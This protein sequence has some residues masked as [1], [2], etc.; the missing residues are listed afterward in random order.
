[1][2][3]TEGLKKNDDFRTVYKTGR[4][5]SHPLFILYVKEN[6]TESN[7]L[8]VVVS[9]KIGNSVVR[10]RVKRLVKETYRLNEERFKRGYDLVFVA[11]VPAKEAGFYEIEEAQL[12]LMRK[13]DLLDI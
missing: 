6:G 3:Y 5:K 2:K 7:R 9:K 1:M 13:Q 4:A 11:R 8:G 12:F 10:H